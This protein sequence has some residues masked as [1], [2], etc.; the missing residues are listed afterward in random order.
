[1]GRLPRHGHRRPVHRRLL[2]L[3]AGAARASTSHGSTPRRPPSRSPP[4]SAATTSTRPTARAATARTARAASA[5]RSTAR[6]SCSPTCPRTTSTTCWWSGVGTSA[7]TRTRMMPV[8]SDTGN[9]PGPF[10]YVQVEDLIA[11]IRAPNNQT[12]TMRDPEL[13]RAASTTRS[14]ARSRRSRAGSTRTTSRRPARRRTR[15]AG[16][17]SSQLRRRPA[18]SGS[19]ARLGVPAGRDDRRVVASG[20]RVHDPGT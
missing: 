15:P 9:P 7:A 5:R 11:F 2:V 13:L 19:P 20:H 12:Y 18:P 17:T 10:N 16:R 4:W 6:T 14:P 3:R 8:W 1:M